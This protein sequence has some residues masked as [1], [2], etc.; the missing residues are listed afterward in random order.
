MIKFSNPN[1]THETAGDWSYSVFS[2]MNRNEFRFGWSVKKGYGLSEP[3]AG[4]R[5]LFTPLEAIRNIT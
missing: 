3:T 4:M 1:V 5:A 2:K